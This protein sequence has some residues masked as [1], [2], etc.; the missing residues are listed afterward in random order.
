MRTN[1]YDKT[2]TVVGEIDLPDKIFN[3]PWNADLVHQALRTQLANKRQVLAHTKNRGEVRGGGKKPWAQKHTGR[4]RHGSIR[5]PIWKGGGV[6]FGPRKERDFSLKINK[7]MRQAAL[8]TILSKQLADGILKIIDSLKIN[9]YRTKDL[10]SELKSYLTGNVSTL[11]IPNVS[12]KNIFKAGANIKKVKS[13]SSHSLNAQ[14]LLRFK[15]I[16]VDKEA[17][18]EI[19]NHYKKIK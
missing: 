13:I 1:L 8:F 10:V 2:G 5:S 9:S 7:K 6:S 19:E 18:A 16:L 11:M 15:Q 17:V 3:R 4:A 14:D 12:E